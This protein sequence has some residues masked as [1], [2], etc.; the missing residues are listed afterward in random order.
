LGGG[1]E[2][3]AAYLYQTAQS[4]LTDKARKAAVRAEAFHEPLQ[5]SHHP[6]EAMT[7]DRVLLGKEA[8]ARVAEKVRQ[9]PERTRDVF[10]LNRFEHVS[11]SEI[12]KMMGISVSAVEKH[13]M[14]A[15]RLLA[16]EMR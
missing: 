3:V 13:I 15:L 5:E 12:A 14:K 7:P 10:M 6:I 11:Y 9:M 8:V 1:I 16:D 2:N 4:V